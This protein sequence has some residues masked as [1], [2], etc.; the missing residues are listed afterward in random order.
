MG[1]GV[2]GHTMTQ[3]PWCRKYKKGDNCISCYRELR[4]RHKKLMEDL[5]FIVRSTAYYRI[6]ELLF[7]RIQEEPVNGIDIQTQP[8]TEGEKEE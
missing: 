3:C 4:E 1:P 6:Q 8:G 7:H 5:K 2:H